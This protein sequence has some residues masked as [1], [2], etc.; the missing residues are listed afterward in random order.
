M[1][2]TIDILGIPMHAEGLTE[3]VNLVIYERPSTQCRLIS[4]TGAHGLVYAQKNK[5][6]KEIIIQF[7][8]NLPDGMPGVWVGRIK[9][10]RNMSRC[11]GPDFF[12]TLISLSAQTSL[13]HYLCGGMPK[14]AEELA[15]VCKKEFGNSNISGTHCPPFLD[16]GSFDYESIASQ[17][18]NCNADIVWI[19]LS[20]PKQEMFAFNLS[21]QLSGKY[22]ITVGAAFDFHTNRVKQA[23]FWIQKIG[24]EWFFRLLIEPK[25]LWRRYFE[26]VPMFIYYNFKE[27]FKKAVN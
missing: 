17:I 9:G 20:T 8:L 14:V 2:Y 23:P 5:G 18:V 22:I 13:K 3:S 27:I 4:A 7:Y 24:M 12:K 10:Q 15:E 6:F 16:V 19:G 21:K 26:I 25:R 11:Y 1:K